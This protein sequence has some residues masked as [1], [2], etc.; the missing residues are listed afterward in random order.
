MKNELNFDEIMAKKEPPITGGELLAEIKLLI[1][2]YFCG[3][4]VQ[5]GHYL[6]YCMP[7]GQQWKLTAKAV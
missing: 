4:I 7:N 5:E 6:T 3:E 2:D 1:D